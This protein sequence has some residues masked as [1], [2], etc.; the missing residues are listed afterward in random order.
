[1]YVFFFEF[2]HIYI[3]I[4][5]WVRENVSSTLGFCVLFKVHGAYIFWDLIISGIAL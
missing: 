2:T 3:Y 5:Q 1:M 4:S